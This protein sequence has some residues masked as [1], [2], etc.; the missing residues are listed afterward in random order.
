MH[1]LPSG[2]WFWPRWK[3]HCTGDTQVW[4]Q[5]ECNDCWG[6]SYQL[7]WQRGKGWIRT[8]CRLEAWEFVCAYPCMQKAVNQG[9]GYWYGGDSLA[10]SLDWIGHLDVPNSCLHLAVLLSCGEDG[11]LLFLALAYLCLATYLW[12][13]YVAPGRRFPEFERWICQPRWWHR[14]WWWGKQKLLHAGEGPG[15][16]D[17]R[18][19]W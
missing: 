9:G 5:C 1:R 8:C 11:S 16:G 7:P 14:R 12:V 17:G 3:A 4:S 2:L 19:Q 18:W 6:V 13:W 10:L 15:Q